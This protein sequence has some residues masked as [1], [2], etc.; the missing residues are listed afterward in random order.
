MEFVEGSILRDHIN[1]EPLPVNE[2]VNILVQITS[3]LAA[4]HQLDIVHRDL[5]TSNVIMTPGGVAKITDF[6]VARPGASELTGSDELLGSATHIAPETWRDGENSPRSDIYALGVIAYELVTGILPFD[7]KSPHELMFKHL[8]LIPVAPVEITSTL[9]RWLNSLIMRMLDKDP[10][11]RPPSAEAVLAEIDLRI[12]RSTVED[13]RGA[14]FNDSA[15]LLD[16]APEIDLGFNEPLEDVDAERVRAPTVSLSPSDR[17]KFSVEPALFSTEEAEAEGQT[18][19]ERGAQKELEDQVPDVT[20]SETFRD[21]AKAFGI[22][23]TFLLLGA[24]IT[25]L[26]P[27]P[28]VWGSREVLTRGLSPT[29]SCA[30]LTLGLWFITMALPQ[31]L[32]H[33]IGGEKQRLSRLV[34]TAL[35]SGGFVVA[36]TLFYAATLYSWS[37]GAT[38]SQLK[39]ILLNAVSA[40][41]AGILGAMGGSAPSTTFQIAQI[42]SSIQVI[43][44]ASSLTAGLLPP[45]GLSA[46]AILFWTWTLAAAG[47]ETLGARN[48]FLVAVLLVVP[49]LLVH[50]ITGPTTPLFVLV[51]GIGFTVANIAA[52]I[53]AWLGAA[54]FVS[55]RRQKYRAECERRYQSE[56]ASSRSSAYSRSFTR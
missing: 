18:L 3:G 49:S 44:G 24:A 12:R 39:P 5:K 33:I 35:I 14:G 52:T 10:A 8:K 31:G 41:Y 27:T 19:L 53:F 21:L 4:I 28:W 7:G 16:E 42:G 30:A 32:T 51:P 25:K 38:L 23:L 13:V 29:L 54:L 50:A 43:P 45:L 34:S 26:A 11:L 46:G 56:I 40:A 37:Y 6:G 9:P 1:G 47:R 15:E 55:R 48:L 20:W 17:L 22:G 36:A 2:A